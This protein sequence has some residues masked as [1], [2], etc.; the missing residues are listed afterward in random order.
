M[1]QHVWQWVGKKH[2]RSLDCCCVIAN[3]SVYVSHVLTNA[4]LRDQQYELNVYS[5]SDVFLKASATLVS[6]VRA[7]C[8]TINVHAWALLDL[9]RHR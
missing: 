4:R 8:Q 6:L 7:V 9:Q 2:E 1:S 3:L 5:L